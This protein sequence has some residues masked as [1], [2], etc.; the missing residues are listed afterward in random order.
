MEEIFFC[1][2]IMTCFESVWPKFRAE[3]HQIYHSWQRK[4]ESCLWH[5]VA[6]GSDDVR[7]KM[8]SLAFNYGWKFQAPSPV[9]DAFFVALIY[10][11]C[12]LFSDQILSNIHIHPLMEDVYLEINPENVLY[13]IFSEGHCRVFMRILGRTVWLQ[14]RK[15]CVTLCKGLKFSGILSYQ[16]FHV[17]WLL[18][19]LT[20]IDHKMVKQWS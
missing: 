12:F 4:D 9:K 19:H 6:E 15:S 10:S 20:L 18:S 14:I 5:T 13:Q 2:A 17:S 8:N 16:D 1:S 3:F 11:I 7:E